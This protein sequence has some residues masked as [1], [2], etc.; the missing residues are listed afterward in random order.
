MKTSN[1]ILI[2]QAKESLKGK[3]GLAIGGCLLTYLISAGLGLIPK[4]G[5]IFVLI[6][7]GP[8]LLG[9]QTFYLSIARNQETKIEQ[10][11]V[12]FNSFGKALG[13]YLLM[14]LYIT[15]WMFLFIVPGIVAAFSYSMAF[16]IL[17]DEPSI[18]ISE[19]LKKS[20]E[21]MKGNKRKYFMLVLPFIA[22]P[23]LV[24]MVYFVFIIIATINHDYLAIV[25]YSGYPNSLQG[26]LTIPVAYV[27][28]SGFFVWM[29]VATAKF[30]DD[31][32]PKEV[33]A[34]TEG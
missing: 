26:K 20:K 5:F 7:G 4:V 19:A 23:L 13:A 17:A 15:L 16:F 8:I 31:I 1:S 18:G 22:I 6:I 11:F 2:S 33:A 25:K 30:Y 29:Y 3:W 14:L 28:T 27:L 34:E 24:I 12:G 9:V 10:I 21:L 32:K